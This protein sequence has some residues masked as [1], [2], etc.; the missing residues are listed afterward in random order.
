MR[1]ETINA[2]RRLNSVFAEKRYKHNE[3]GIISATMR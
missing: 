1:N 3:K 2:E